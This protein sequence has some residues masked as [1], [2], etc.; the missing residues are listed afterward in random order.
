MKTRAGILVLTQKR[1]YMGHDFGLED[2]VAQ[3]VSC[4][5]NRGIRKDWRSPAIGAK[6]Q[7]ALSFQ[8]LF[9][10]IKGEY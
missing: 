6:S 2:I 1:S 10:M 3:K 4:A 9:K 8:F 5:Q 7:S